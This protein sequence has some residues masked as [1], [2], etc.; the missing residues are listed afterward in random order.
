[1]QELADA[2][3]GDPKLFEIHKLLD[4]KNFDQLERVWMDLVDSDVLSSGQADGL[5]GAA[6]ELIRRGFSGRAGP[7]LDL[8]ASAVE[9]D[10]SVEPTTRL[11]LAEMLLRS[12]PGN[13]DFLVEYVE[14]FHE[15]HGPTTSERAFFVASGIAETADPIL[16]LSRFDCLMRFQPGAVVYHE[17]GWGIGEVLSVDPLLGQVCVDLAEKKDHR[18]AIEAVDTIL[19]VLPRGSFRELLYRG[20]DE[21]RALAAEDPVRLVEKVIDDVG[22]PLPQK[23]IKARIVPSV[24][25]AKTWTRWWTQA[26]KRLRESGFYRVG[27]RA[28]YMVERLAEQL[29]FEDDLL[30]RFHGGEWMDM[31]LAAR[32]VLKGGVRSFP[33]AH[34]EVAESC[35]AYVK[36]VG[37]AARAIE[38]AALLARYESVEGASELLRETF[39]LFST[40]EVSVALASLPTGEEF[41][42][43]FPVLREARPEDW[44]QIVRRLFLGRTDSLRAAACSYLEEEAPDTIRALAR[45]IYASPRH[46]PDTCC[47]LLEQRLRGRHRLSL[48]AIAERNP[49]ALF[50]LLMDLL[51]HLVDREIREGRNS[52][53]DLYRRVES[54]M[55]FEKG[56]FF[57]AAVELM[58][59]GARLHVHRTL[60]RTQEKLARV[61][62]RLL[63]ILGSIEP[64]IAQ[65]ESIP[66]WKN[67]DIIFSTESGHERKREELRVLREDK[68]PAIFKAIGDAAELGDLS[69]NAEFTSAIEERDNLVRKAEQ[70]QEDLD[71]VRIIDVTLQKDGLVGLGARIRVRNLE[72]SE[73]FVY[74]MLGPWDGSPTEEVLNY[75]SPLGQ[76]FLGRAEGEEVHV[77]LPS[78]TVDYKILAIGSH[79]E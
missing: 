46:S 54:L 58:D 37:D 76:F 25:D 15:C 27:D 39:S 30:R 21:L 6:G 18:I 24:M 35:A 12:T 60:V 63:E 32:Q 17:S 5:L 44:V 3:S 55:Y 10:G 61:A 7:L 68:L 9:G 42:K 29:S 20:G 73:E 49:R 75:R 11:R 26:K 13:R 67:D 48:E 14:R 19:D 71:K 16:A 23:E 43:L 4:E 38:M 47:W 74:S 69:E 45:D 53:K 64:V 62:T 66:D 8:L 72:T 59:S 77:E 56:E 28:P 34:Q 41:G 79:F 22:N 57:R 36:T 1:M 40:D 78:G 52:V 33:E 65:E 50:V 2:P 31:R 70:V 51:E